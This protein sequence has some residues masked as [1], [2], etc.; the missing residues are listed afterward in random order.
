M[1]ARTR[2]TCVILT[3]VVGT[4][5]TTALADFDVQGK[6]E[7]EDRPYTIAGFTGAVANRPIRFADVQVVDVTGGGNTVLKQGATDAAGAF[8]INGVPASS[9]MDIEVRCIASTQQTADMSLEVRDN[10]AAPGSSNLWAISKSFAG[11]AADQDIDFT[12]VP[13][14]ARIHDTTTAPAEGDGPGGAFNI[15]DI[16][17][18]ASNWVKNINA[19]VAPNLV[20]FY[21]Q[22]GVNVGS[23]FW[24]PDQIF[25][26]GV[27]T[28]RDE[29][30]DPVVLH[31]YGH[32]VD[33]MFW[34]LRTPGGNHTLRGHGDPRL[35]ISEGFATYFSSVV[36]AEDYYVDMNAGGVANDHSLESGGRYNYYAFGSSNEVCLEMVLWDISDAVNDD[37]DC[38]SMGDDEIWDVLDNYMNGATLA[39]TPEDFRDGWVARGHPNLAGVD[40]TLN[41][42]LIEFVPSPHRNVWDNDFADVAIPD[43]SAAGV[44][45]TI[46]IGNDYTI[47]AITDVDPKQQSYSLCAYVELDH[48]AHVPI[49]PG[50][51]NSMQ[52]NKD[53]EIKL[54]APDGTVVTL[55]DKAGGGDPNVPY[56]AK[57]WANGGIYSWFGL[58]V[59]DLGGGRHAWLLPVPANALTTLDT[60]NLKGTWKLKVA[61]VVAGET[62]TFRRWGLA[63]MRSDWYDA[64]DSYGTDVV[65]LNHTY[66]WLGAAASHEWGVDDQWDTDLVDNHQPVNT[67]LADDGVTLDG[68]YTP[69]EEGQVEFVVT[70]LG[71]K[72]SRYLDSDNTTKRELYVR[73]WFDWN[74]NGTFDDPGERMV[75]WHESPVDWA[76]CVDTKTVSATFDVPDGAIEGAS[77]VR[78][79]VAYDDPPLPTGAEDF[80]E[81][82]DYPITIPE[83]DHFEL[84]LAAITVD[85]GP[86]GTETISFQGPATVAVDLGSLADGDGN[87]LEEVQTEMVEMNLTG[88]SALWGPVSVS[89]RPETSDPFLPSTGVIEETVNNTPGVLDIPPFAPSGTASSH[90]DVFFEIDLSGQ[91]YYNSDPKHMSPP[92]GM[93][94]KPPHPEDKPY[95]D[96]AVIVLWRNGVMTSVYV[97]N[98]MHQPVPPPPD[99]HGTATPAPY[100]EFGSGSGAIP[101]IPYGFFEP[102]SDVW[103]GRIDL[104]GDPI[105]PLKTGDAAT[106]FQRW[107]SPV[108]SDDP[109]GAT[110]DTLLKMVELSLVSTAPIIVTHNG[111]LNPEEWQVHVSLSDVPPGEIGLLSATKT[112]A[113]GGTFDT[114]VYVQPKFTFTK[115]MDP[116]QLRIMD[117]GLE[118]QPPLVFTSTGTPFV[119]SLASGLGILAPDDGHF[120][121]MVEEV[122]PGVQQVVAM[123]PEDPSAPAGHSM[124]PATTAGACVTLEDFAEFVA[125]L[126][127]PD[128]P[129][130]PECV[131]WD[132]DDSGHVD[133]GDF[134]LVQEHICLEEPDIGAC[135]DG[136]T[137]IMVPEAEC[138]GIFLDA[139]IL[140]GPDSCT[141][142]M[143]GEAEGF[144]AGQEVTLCDV[145][146]SS[147]TDLVASSNSK[148]FQMQDA[149]GGITVYGSNADI[150]A[151][152]A[153]VGE[154]DL[155]DL[156]GTTAEYQGLFQFIAPFFIEDVVGNVGV[157]APIPT[158]PADYQEGSGVAE[159]LESKLVVLAGVAF[160][161]VGT[162][163][164]GNYIVSPDGGVTTVTVR[165]ATADLNLVGEPIP[166]GPVTLMG[167][168]SQYDSSEPFDDGYQLLPRSMADIY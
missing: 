102:D 93:T 119:H 80:G 81:V 140:C 32:A 115:V 108:R 68:L 122:F 4:V 143:I 116:G 157:P 133:L 59:G 139:G 26:L 95:L 35:A 118:E 127:G 125:C 28:D 106:M 73:G 92:G 120:V 76:P 86:M 126:G 148:S 49:D 168:F 138:P 144:G 71:A 16:C 17:A 25:I 51:P 97:E 9:V 163:A 1:R 94:Y 30:D 164:P 90:L 74:R 109:T 53:L 134:G 130:S 117:T 22:P 72:R 99:P 121:P 151:I 110:G 87:G 10:P 103:S 45:R 48:T 167:I 42:R 142:F 96:P 155:I 107:G 91:V 31:E 98:T 70:T 146:V 38:V 57:G 123:Y 77:W 15:L 8:T 13:G 37:N 147:T 153:A 135:C 63:V 36:R 2:T 62:G 27:N 131:Q 150:D 141:C 33:F 11:H 112:H 19:N 137:C 7:Y 83:M 67:D 159:E 23:Y 166:V 39:K 58:A 24:S 34:N 128:V 84:S 20:R 3:M 89:L 162:F 64:P 105:S 111:G 132:G 14:V 161:E 44:E 101:P 152:L 75:D 78:F 154:G 69:G 85:A 47:P 55:Y 114:M 136:P 165:I 52:V 149:T 40:E 158:V 50:D 12:A 88:E 113:N 124:T 43:N 56:F 41:G 79:R 66:E 160:Q 100:V 129:V 5:A 145:V 18:G 60:K 46:V 6:F 21:W 156:R 29:Y 65:H 104:M 54:T 82:E 61:D